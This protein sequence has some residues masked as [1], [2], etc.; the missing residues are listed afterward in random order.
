MPACRPSLRVEHVVPLARTGSL[1]VHHRTRSR[2]YVSCGLASTVVPW[3]DVPT[4]WLDDFRRSAE[5]LR[6][7]YRKGGVFVGMHGVGRRA[8]P[9]GLEFHLESC[10]L[11][12]S[13]GY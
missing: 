4:R 6:D 12:L 1:P 5:V 3:A 8:S 10:A 13:V 9:S 11:V 7:V 2:R